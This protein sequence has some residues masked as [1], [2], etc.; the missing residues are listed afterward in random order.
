MTTTAPHTQSADTQAGSWR[1][2]LLTTNQPANVDTLL[3]ELA[4]VLHA[5][6]QCGPGCWWIR[7]GDT[8]RLRL[9]HP[10]PDDVDQITAAA[11][12]HGAQIHPGIYEPE[13]HGFGG[14]AGIR[15]AH[16]VGCHDA[17]HLAGH[18]ARHRQHHHRHEMFLLL[19]TRL[20]RAA[21]LDL[22]EQGD[23]WSR[24]AAHRPPPDTVAAA[25]RR[26]VRHLIFSGP[27]TASSPN[28]VKL[29]GGSC[30]QGS[31]TASMSILMVALRLGL[32]TRPLAVLAA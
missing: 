18:L 29:G 4:P 23:V 9:W 15:V 6:G 11:R 1:Q 5:V 12:Q 20:M 10:D 27:D 19:A 24:V 8:L 17:H 7:K 13:T 26:A 3:I 30:C 22:E 31:T 16:R 21:G 2:L 25:T 32:R 14:E 28:A